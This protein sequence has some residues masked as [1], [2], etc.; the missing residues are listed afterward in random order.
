MR[1][2]LAAQATKSWRELRRAKIIQVLVKHLIEAINREQ[3][4]H[5]GHFHEKQRV[6]LRV[7]KDRPSE[8]RG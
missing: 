8:S 2:V 7:F 6:R 1:D 3:S 4:V 5:A